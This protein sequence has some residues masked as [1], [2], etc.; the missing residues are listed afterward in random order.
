MK[1]ERRKTMKPNEVGFRERRAAIAA[2]VD[3]VLQGRTSDQS[4]YSALLPCELRELLKFWIRVAIEIG[5]YQFLTGI[6]DLFDTR[7]RDLAWE[8]IKAIEN[9]LGSDE[10]V[11]LLEGVRDE[12]GPYEDPRYWNV[13]WDGTPEEMHTAQEEARHL[14]CK[15]HRKEAA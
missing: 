8:R 13:F 9:L 7:C 2:L 5:Y 14:E 4:D 10:V 1:S 6:G 12:L 11:D 3:R 15:R